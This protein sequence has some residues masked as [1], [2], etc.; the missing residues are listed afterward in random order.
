LAF[1]RHRDRKPISPPRAGADG[2][3]RERLFASALNLLAA[4]PRSERQLRERLAE[5]Y[6]AVP[7][8]IDECIAR[9]KELGYI[10]DRRLAENYASAR[11]EAKPIGRARL[12]RELA[13]KQVGRATI[14]EALDAVFEE[15]DEDALIDRAIEQRVRTQGRPADRNGVK[16]L[17]DYLARRGF[18][19][20]LIARKLHALKAESD[21]NEENE[22]R[23][24]E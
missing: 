13:R 11:V 5:K 3:V 12:A 1:R 23:N 9:L 22:M 17:G 8:L 7:E 10:D 19:Y 4:R 15:T 21:E 6:E 20:G 14:A 16:R 24:D 2:R 18:G